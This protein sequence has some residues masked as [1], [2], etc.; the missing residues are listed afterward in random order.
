MSSNETICFDT[1][2]LF[3]AYSRASG[4]PS[5]N[6]FCS[7]TES[8]RQ[9]YGD[10]A[11]TIF[12]KSPALWMQFMR[13]WKINNSRQRDTT[14]D[15]LLMMGSRAIALLETTKSERKLGNKYFNSVQQVLTLSMCACTCVRVCVCVCSFTWYTLI[16][17]I[18]IL[19]ANWGHFWKE[20]SFWLVLGKLKYCLRGKTW[21]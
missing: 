9:P 4:P 3:S 19:L 16:T 11:Y 20:R 8:E 2:F 18:C 13:Y 7:Q 12:S 15:E 6:S 14:D 21:I 10:S 1:F 5:I 17:K